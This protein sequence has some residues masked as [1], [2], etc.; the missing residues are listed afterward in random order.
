[1]MCEQI[2][3]LSERPPRR[4]QQVGV[5]LIALPMSRGRS[6]SLARAQEFTIF[7]DPSP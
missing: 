4:Q 5:A 1:M 3:T 7:V 6:D 2:L